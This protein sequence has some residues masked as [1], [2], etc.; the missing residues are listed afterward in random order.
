MAASDAGA[1]HPSTLDGAQTVKPAHL[2]SELRHF[3]CQVLLVHSLWTVYD[4]MA[5][6]V[7]PSADSAATPV[8]PAFGTKAIAA[9]Q[10]RSL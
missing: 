1:L 10:D 3:G 4:C 6:V 8:A 2:L 9:V 7:A 5:V